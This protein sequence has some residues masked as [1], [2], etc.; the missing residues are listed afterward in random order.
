MAGEVVLEPHVHLIDVG[1]GIGVEK[2][3]MDFASMVAAASLLSFLSF[4]DSEMSS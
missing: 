2:P 4:L 1:S 3:L